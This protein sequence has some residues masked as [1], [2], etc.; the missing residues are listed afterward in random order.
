MRHDERRHRRER[1][2]LHRLD[3]RLTVPVK[4]R[5]ALAGGGDAVELG[6]FALVAHPNVMLGDL[7]LSGRLVEAV[8]P[9]AVTTIRDGVARLRL[10]GVVK[11]RIRQAVD[12]RLVEA[13]GQKVGNRAHRLMGAVID[14]LHRTETGAAADL[15]LLRR[16]SHDTGAAGLLAA[17]D[18]DIVQHDGRREHFRLLQHLRRYH[19]FRRN[20][21]GF[22]HPPSP[23]TD[24]ARHPPG[25]C[26]APRSPRRG[27]QGSGRARHQ[28]GPYIP[29]APRSPGPPTMS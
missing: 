21:E 15:E 2:L 22:R 3:R 29:H 10:L 26:S 12:A 5:R 16:N 11:V 27:P 8:G 4:N 9:G 14:L 13:I 28:S 24:R 23:R 6:L 7:D 1:H 19:G 17:H 18:L 20:G 25:S